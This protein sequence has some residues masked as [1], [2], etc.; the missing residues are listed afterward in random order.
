MGDNSQY[1]FSAV[2]RIRGADLSGG[3]VLG[4]E[5]QL[6]RAVRSWPRLP[7]RGLDGITRPNGRSEPDSVINQRVWI[8]VPDDSHDRPS[9][10][11]EGTQS[12]EN[13]TSKTR[14]LAYP[15]IYGNL[16]SARVARIPRG[17]VNP[18]PMCRGL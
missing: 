10:E 8:V 1:G 14:R 7:N 13:D 3:K 6:S 11:A 2:N 18:L 9:N 16:L 15:G 17:C 4:F 5:R 12:V